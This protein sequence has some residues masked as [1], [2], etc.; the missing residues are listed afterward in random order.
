MKNSC[1]KKDLQVWLGG[2]KN[3]HE[4]NKSQTPLFCV[5]CA[6]RKKPVKNMVAFFESSFFGFVRFEEF[7]R[8]VTR[9]GT[10]NFVLFPRFSFILSS[11]VLLWTKFTHARTRFSHS[12]PP[13]VQNDVSKF[14]SPFYSVFFW[15]SNSE[16]FLHKISFCI[17][18]LFTFSVV[19][20]FVDMCTMTRSFLVPSSFS[21]PMLSPPTSLST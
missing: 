15:Q 18:S 13:D 16:G 1:N 17:F 9:S 20:L 21:F 2:E 10:S 19:F 11:R 14:S 8:R 6:R 7:A 4:Q 5:S 12:L 3:K